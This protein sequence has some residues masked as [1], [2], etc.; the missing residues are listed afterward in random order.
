MGLP[1][2][3]VKAMG[4][5][6]PQEAEGYMRSF[7]QRRYYGLRANTL[8]ITAEGLK[9]LL[10]FDLT[11]VPWCEAGFYYP[12]NERP[13]KHIL[14]RAGLFLYTGAERNGARGGV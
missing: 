5:N 7:S 2:F 1:D 3:F 6:F 4:E 13:A 11:P 12:E 14:Y 9:N 10:P 8:K